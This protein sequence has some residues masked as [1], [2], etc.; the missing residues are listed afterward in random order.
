MRRSVGTS[1]GV[2]V[3][4][5]KIPPTFEVGKHV[6][7]GTAR[8]LARNWRT[9]QRQQNLNPS[10][11]ARL[12]LVDLQRGSQVLKTQDKIPFSV[13]RTCRATISTALGKACP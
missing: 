7:L 12:L 2:V 5:V 10:R 11:R 8:R 1:V 6:A 9:C 3:R 4:S 13:S